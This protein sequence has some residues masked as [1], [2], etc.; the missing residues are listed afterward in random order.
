MQ[1]EDEPHFTIWREMPQGAHGNQSP[2]VVISKPL[3]TDRV[4]ELQIDDIPYTLS[5]VFVGVGFDVDKIAPNTKPGHAERCRV[6]AMVK[7]GKMDAANKSLCEFAC[8][9]KSIAA[10]RYGHRGKNPLTNRGAAVH[11]PLFYNKP[12]VQPFA[13]TQQDR[14]SGSLRVK[15]DPVQKCLSFDFGH[16]WVAALS[17]ELEESGGAALPGGPIRWYML[18]THFQRSLRVTHSV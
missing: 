11:L 14:G 13:A 15:V 6:N 18:L 3:P 5:S 2:D 7:N 12:G 4:S 16:G 9:E 17:P 1:S 10:V 8:L